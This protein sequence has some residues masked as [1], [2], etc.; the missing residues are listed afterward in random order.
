M[1]PRIDALCNRVTFTDALYLSRKGTYASHDIALQK[2][3]NDGGRENRS[4]ENGREH[5]PL[6][7]NSTGVDR[8]GSVYSQDEHWF[9][10]DV[11]D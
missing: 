10:K 6:T 3:E 7:Q 8:A 5:V 11:G 4:A 9:A 1:T 2:K